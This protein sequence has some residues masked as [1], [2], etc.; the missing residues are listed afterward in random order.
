GIYSYIMPN[1]WLQAG[2]GK[3]LRKF[4]LTKEFIQLINFGDL[5]IFE[6]ATTYP[7]IFVARNAE[8]KNEFDVAVLT[9]ANEIDFNTNVRSNLETFSTKEFSED[10]WVISSKRENELLERLNESFISL[11]EFVSG[12]ANYGLKTGLTKAFLIS[13]ETK[14]ELVESDQ[15]AIDHIEPFLQGRD[16]K[17]YLKANPKSFLILFKK[18]FTKGQLGECTEDE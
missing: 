13:G 4:F 11:N 16:I 17:R 5:Q 6:D 12:N 1:K 15:K 3:P 9:A 18:G 7:C 10:T 14:N 8:P 2:Y